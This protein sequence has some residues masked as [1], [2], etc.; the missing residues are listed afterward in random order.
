MNQSRTCTNCC[1]NKVDESKQTFIY[2]DWMGNKWDSCLRPVCNDCINAGEYKDED[3]I[4]RLY[5]GTSRLN[6]NQFEM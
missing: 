6:K 2:R 5:L 3:G 1:E 4:K